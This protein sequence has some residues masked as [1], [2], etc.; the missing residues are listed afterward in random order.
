MKSR[1][2]KWSTVLVGTAF[3]VA[4]PGCDSS[5]QQILQQVLSTLNITLPS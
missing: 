1:L 5:W 3:A 2:F 4:V